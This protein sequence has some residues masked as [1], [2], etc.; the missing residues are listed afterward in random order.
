M[1]NKIK[2]GIYRHFK[3]DQ[4]EVV[5][6]ALHS[7]TLEEFVVYKHISGDKANESHFW[8]R[9]IAMFSEEVER[10]GKKQPRFKFFHA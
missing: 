6:I 2:L 10:D 1:E 8:I 3:G 5:G 4:I 9:P 7:E